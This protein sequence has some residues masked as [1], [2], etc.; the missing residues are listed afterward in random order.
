[1][2]RFKNGP[3]RL[4]AQTSQNNIAASIIELHSKIDRLAPKRDHPQANYFSTMGSDR[5]KNGQTT[6]RLRKNDGGSTK[7]LP[8]ANS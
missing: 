6:K 7:K 3:L 8:W 2:N 1:M 4:E 5:Q